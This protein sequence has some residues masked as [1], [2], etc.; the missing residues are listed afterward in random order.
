VLSNNVDELRLL[1]QSV[2][3]G[4][5]ECTLWNRSPVTIVQ[6][7]DET[8]ERDNTI[9][10]CEVCEVAFESGRGGSVIQKD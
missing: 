5:N 4:Q 2:V 6:S 9:V 1:E 7:I 8:F 10:G 3:E